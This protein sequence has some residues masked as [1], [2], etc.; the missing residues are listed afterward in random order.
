VDEEATALRPAPHGI[1]RHEQDTAKGQVNQQQP[2]MKRSFGE[3]SSP[4]RKVA[5]RPDVRVVRIPREICIVIQLAALSN[6][7][8]TRLSH[9]RVKWQFKRD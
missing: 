4:L 3:P 9:G 6:Q 8:K 2:A 7:T 1:T 5:V